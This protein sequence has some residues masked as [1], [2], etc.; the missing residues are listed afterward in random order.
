MSMGARARY[1]R[2]TMALIFAGSA[3]IG[4]LVG[5]FVGGRDAGAI[6]QGVATGLLIALG[7]AALN[8]LQQ[9]S[10]LQRVARWPM[11]GRL[12][13]MSLLYGLVIVSAI[14]IADAVVTRTYVDVRMSDPA[15]FRIVLVSVAAAIA[16][17]LVLMI[18]DMLG[19]R[20]L[21]N[22]VTGRY[23]RPRVEPRFFL[24]IDLADSTALAERLGAVAFLRLLDAWLGEVAVAA[25]SCKG[26][27]YKYVGDQ[28]IVTWK[29]AEGAAEGRAVACAPLLRA[30]LAK[31]AARYRAEFGTVPE[32]RAALHFGPAV[33]GELGS[34]KREIAFLG[35]T[36]NVAAR[37]EQHARDI[38]RHYLISAEALAALALPPS[39]KA[40]AL[41]EATFRGRAQ[42]T[43][44]FAI[45]ES[46][47]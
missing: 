3:A 17:N 18:V 8:Y 41:Q 2:R 19:P 14:R 40:E 5:W 46:A 12:L 39:L 31:Q 13:A 44:I 30:A 20:A 45:E 15:L 23:H 32:F 9:R 47:A 33:V 43:R 22:F 37:L 28:A 6:G 38:G 29:A 34:V 11:L 25:A 35:D 4:A 42:P 36:V 10:W 16:V 1:D 7:L 21:L 26:E 27:I 24:F